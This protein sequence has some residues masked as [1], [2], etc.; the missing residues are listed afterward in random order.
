MQRFLNQLVPFILLGV[1][2][3]IFIFGITLLV[4]I[5]MI[6]AMVGFILYLVSLIREKFFPAKTVA[7]PKENKPGRIIDSDDWKEL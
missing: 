7:K 5:A 1:A 6:G 4:Y 2:I 3:V